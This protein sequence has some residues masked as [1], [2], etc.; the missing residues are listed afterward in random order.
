MSA[1][2][3]LISNGGGSLLSGLISAGFYLF[4]FKREYL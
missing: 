3:I 4:I 2:A 1:I